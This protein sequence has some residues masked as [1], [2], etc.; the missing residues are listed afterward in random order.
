MLNVLRIQERTG[1]AV[2]LV[3]GIGMVMVVVTVKCLLIIDVIIHFL[4]HHQMIMLVME[5]HMTQR[6]L[7]N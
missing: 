6:V 3:I 4:T 5:H 7:R 2:L 1:E